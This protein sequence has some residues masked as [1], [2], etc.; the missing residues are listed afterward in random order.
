VISLGERIDAFM[1]AF[2][3]N[4]APWPWKVREAGRDVLYGI[5]LTGA[6][7]G[8]NGLYGN[9]PPR[10]LAYLLALFPDVRLGEMLHA[11]SGSLKPGP[12]T[13]LDIRPEIPVGDGATMTVVRPDVVGNVYDAAQLLGGRRFKLVIAD[14]PYSA[15][16]AQQYGT[17]GVNALKA[18]TALA[19]VLTPDGYL[20]W[21]DETWP[22]HTKRELVTVGRFWLVLSTGRHYRGCTVF[23]RVSA[24]SSAGDADTPRRPGSSR[25]A[26]CAAAGPEST[27]PSTP[28]RPSPSARGP[29]GRR[30]AGSQASSDSV[31]PE[32]SSC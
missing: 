15:K 16:H 2:P 32:P 6:Q 13:R 22:I 31:A 24:V 11:F 21:L 26:G 19:Q 27:R 28:R 25:P 4:S 30:A 10:F 9:F 20:A 23:Q 29:R 3:K 12:W 18:T 1:Q 7:Y 17:K 8:G 14:P 5:W